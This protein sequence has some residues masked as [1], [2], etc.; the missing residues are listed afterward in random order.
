MCDCCLNLELFDFAATLVLRPV[1]LLS[2]ELCLCSR[3]DVSSLLLIALNL[4]ILGI[5]SMGTLPTQ[6]IIM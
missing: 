1:S 3:L 6:H 5:L 2:C 4:G